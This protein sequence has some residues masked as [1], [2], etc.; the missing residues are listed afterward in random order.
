MSSDD[1]MNDPK[2]ETN[3]VYKSHECH[4][5]YKSLSAITLKRVDKHKSSIREKENYNQEGQTL[6]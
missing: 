3:D 2:I 1:I 4:T 6:M 5:N